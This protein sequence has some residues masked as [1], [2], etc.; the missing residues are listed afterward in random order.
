M[1]AFLVKYVDFP[2]IMIFS[3][4]TSLGV[5]LF[6]CFSLGVSLVVV[7]AAIILIGFFGK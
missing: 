2:D 7:G 6:L 1:K 5:G 3:G 4:L